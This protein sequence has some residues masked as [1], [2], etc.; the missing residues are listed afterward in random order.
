MRSSAGSDMLSKILTARTEEKCKQS[1]IHH[2]ALTS[3][4]PSSGVS[5]SVL[6]AASLHYG[7]ASGGNDGA[8]CFQFCLYLEE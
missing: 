2:A 3:L 6:H 7:A 4:K 5:G 8:S 1:V